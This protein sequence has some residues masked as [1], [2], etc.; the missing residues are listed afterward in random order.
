VLLPTLTDNAPPAYATLIGQ[1][2]F[3]TPEQASNALVNSKRHF[4]RTLRAVIAETENMATD[5]EIDAE[6]ADLRTTLQKAGDLGL[7]WDRVLITGPQ[8]REP[9]SFPAVIESVDKSINESNPSELAGLLSVRG[10]AEGNWDPAEL[11]D[12][13]R[14]CLSAP[15]SEYL[16]GVAGTIYPSAEFAAD[17]PS[18]HAAA[19]MPLGEL[20]HCADPPLG[21]L[22]AVKTRARR[23]TSPGTSDVPVEIHQVVYF[24][25]IAAALVRHG[26]LISKS[27]PD[28]L[29]IG[30]ER[31]GGEAYVEEGLRRLF[32]AAVSRV[33]DEGLGI[34]D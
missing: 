21:L 19:G 17:S 25:A 7:E 15:A 29:R 32:E 33:G 12:L 10:T 27:G 18:E 20:L 13:L 28:V 4:A 9:E 11:G 23:L 34:R 1:F 8:G 5:A 24:A 30:W 2:G 14:H 31:L 26:E 6:I 16:R 3:R 22:I